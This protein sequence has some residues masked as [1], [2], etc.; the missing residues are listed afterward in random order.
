MNNETAHATD[1]SRESVE[2][3]RSTRLEN[4]RSLLALQDKCH[5]L[6]SGYIERDKLKSEIAD[7]EESLSAVSP[8]EVEQLRAEVRT[9]TAKAKRFWMMRCEQMLEKDELME[10]KELEIASLRAQLA[11][12]RTY[13][14]TAIIA[15]AQEGETTHIAVSTPKP[16]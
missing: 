4:E 5:E 14:D 10:A 9:Q 15:T 11:A 2:S 6:E 16:Q 13:G 3:L 12:A 8:E 7:L 1:A